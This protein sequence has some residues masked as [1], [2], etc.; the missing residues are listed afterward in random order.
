MDGGQDEPAGYY[1][2]QRARILPEGVHPQI[3]EPDDLYLPEG[4]RAV[5]LPPDK[6]DSSSAAN[7]SLDDV[8]V[9]P[10]P[11]P[12]VMPRKVK[13]TLRGSTSASFPAYR[14]QKVIFADAY[15]AQ[16]N[17]V[18]LCKDCWLQEYL[19]DCRAVQNRAMLHKCGPSCY[20]YSKDGVRIC[21]HHV[22]HLL[23]FDPDTAEK[24]LRIRREGRP[25][26]NVVKI[27]EDDSQG[28]RGRLELIREHPTETTTNYVG[29]VCM[30]CN[31]DAQTLVRLL[32]PSILDSGPLSSIVSKP[33]WGAMN[34][35]LP[36]GSPTNLVLPLS[37]D[38]SEDSDAKSADL[39]ELI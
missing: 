9:P 23:S 4:A 19:Q 25:L 33:E 39:N 27:I 28:Q 36:D 7:R 6:T 35:A 2:K 1:P 37:D 24:P 29:A 26:N 5:S 38:D 10:P 13:V 15:R 34:T 8:S 18:E 31:L 16:H 32:F 17:T 3:L 30:R 21:R 11:A 22:Y 12:S 14:R 20:K